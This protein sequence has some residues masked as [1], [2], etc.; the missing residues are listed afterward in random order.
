MASGT[1]GQM[2]DINATEYSGYHPF[3]DDAGSEHGSFEVFY[4]ADNGEDESAGW[5]WHACFPGCIPDGDPSGPFVT[6]RE[7]YDDAQGF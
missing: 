3:C 6:S 2:P 7:A 5:Y 1:E 4:F